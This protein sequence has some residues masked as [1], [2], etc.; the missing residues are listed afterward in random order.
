MVIIDCFGWRELMIN[1]E[2]GQPFAK[3]TLWGI[4]AHLCKISMLTFWTL[5]YNIPKTEGPGILLGAKG[6]FVWVISTLTFINSTSTIGEVKYITATWRTSK[7]HSFSYYCRVFE[8]SKTT[9]SEKGTLDFT[10]ESM[11]PRDFGIIHAKPDDQWQSRRLFRIAL[12]M[13]YY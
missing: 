3:G 6:S 12:L 10:V 8:K 11:W 2:S 1:C 9:S 5:W 4:K 13:Q 7:C